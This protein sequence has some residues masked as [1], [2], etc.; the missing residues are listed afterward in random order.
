LWNMLPTKSTVYCLGCGDW[1]P[2]IEQQIEANKIRVQTAIHACS[3]KQR[4]QTLFLYNIT[5]T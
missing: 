2:E 4:E 5:L 3:P 1:E